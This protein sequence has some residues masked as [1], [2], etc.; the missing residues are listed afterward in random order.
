M[1]ELS[2]HSLVLVFTDDFFF[3]GLLKIGEKNLH[4]FRILILNL[5]G[6]LGDAVLHRPFAFFLIF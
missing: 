4:P 1:E 6:M 2:F 5:T 3:E